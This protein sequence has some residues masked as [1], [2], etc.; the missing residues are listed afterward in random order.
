MG[1]NKDAKN[2]IVPWR[3]DVCVKVFAINKQVFKT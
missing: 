1:K 2:I 3:Y